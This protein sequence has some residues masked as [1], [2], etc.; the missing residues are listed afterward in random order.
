[1]GRYL[2]KGREVGK[3]KGGRCETTYDKK[4]IAAMISK[5]FDKQLETNDDNNDQSVEEYI[6][7]VVNL[8]IESKESKEENSK[9]SKVSLCSILKA[10]KYSGKSA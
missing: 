4:S 5:E 2:E 8:V 1:M 7:S 3:G 6:A 9:E 10:A